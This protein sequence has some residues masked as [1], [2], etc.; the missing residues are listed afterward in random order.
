MNY[1]EK[2]KQALERA[3]NMLSYKEVRHEDMEY[4]F[5]ELAES[6]DK[7]IRKAILELVKQSSEI[8]G[9]QN[10]NNMITW[11][12]KQC[13]PADNVEPKF[14][15]GNWVILDGTVAQILDKQKYGFV[16]LDIDGKDFF[17]NYGHT[18]SMRLWTINDAKDGDILVNG[19]NIFIFHF[20][21]DTRLMGY[22][23]V[24]IDDERFYDDIGRNECF[25]LIDAVVNPATKK[26]RDLLFQKMKEAGYKWNDKKKELNRIEPKFKSSNWI[27]FNGL[28]LYIYEI[29]DGYYKTVDIDGVHCS[30]DWAIDN[31]ARLWTIGD[32]KDGDVLVASDESIFIYAGSTDKYAKFYVGL[33]GTFNFDGG[34]WDNK[35][36]VHP[37]TK[38]QCDFLFQKMTKAGYKWDAEKK[39]LKKIELKKIEQKFHHGDWITDGYICYKIIEILD[40]RYIIESKYDKRSAILFEY[41]NRYHL[42]SINDAKDG[43]VLAINWNED[44]DSFEKI[45]IFKKYHNKGVK[46]LFNTPCVEGYGNTFKNGKLAFHEEVPYYSKTWTD[47]LYPATKDQYELL[48]QN[49]KE[50]G[51]EWDNEKKELKRIEQ[52][53]IDNVEPKFK[54]R[55]WIVRSDGS[56]DIPI[57]VYGLKK[58]I[59][60]VTNMLGSK[61]KLMINRQDE[62]YLWT[63]NDAKD[64]DV[65]VTE[66]YIFIFKYI[67]HGGVHLYCH[68]NFDDEEFDSDIPDAVIGNIHDKGIHFRPA[69]K[70]QHDL[71][72]SKMKQEG[73]EWDAKNKKLSK[74]TLK[75]T[76]KFCVGQLI[77]DNNGNWYKILNIECLDD[78]YYKVYDIAEDKTQL[79]LC[80]NIDE[81]FRKIR[82][83]NEIKKMMG[84]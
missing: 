20:I 36:A 34:N 8:L 37:A 51:Y 38:E 21:S 74:Q 41:E 32:A 77:T 49:M 69:T 75:I 45:I 31:I 14:R 71:L 83:V 80:S 43:D 28:T 52:K 78:W 27:V 67:L 11:L 25:C 63:I 13:E 58:D 29:V 64:G 44:N 73:Y 10:Q 60:L 57:Q 12:E 81:K 9:K 55:D 24:N 17:C 76:P 84:D 22:C 18:D 26:Q 59:Y 61:G 54:V 39:E 33:C 72:F 35:N 15:H 48:F 3:K 46:G 56:S 5:P 65:L 66:D 40:D 4:L 62:W 42:W 79:E 19:S 82:F 1:E 16:G 50:A 2:Y 68:Y 7:K 6:E 30:Y 53:P 23:H 70:E 47:N